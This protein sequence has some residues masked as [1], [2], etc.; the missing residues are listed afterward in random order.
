MFGNQTIFEPLENNQVDK[1]VFKF[2]QV[3][4]EADERGLTAAGTSYEEIQ[5]DLTK[6]AESGEITIKDLKDIE[7]N[8]FGSI[9]G[10]DYD[11]AESFDE[12]VEETYNEL[13]IEYEA[14]HTNQ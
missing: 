9:S 3:L 8:Y 1:F 6:H 12:V 7:N 14:N 13:G 10:L 5:K 11:L 4:D 2:Y